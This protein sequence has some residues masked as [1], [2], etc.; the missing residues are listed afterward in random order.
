MNGLIIMLRNPDD[1]IK[2]KR[3]M[4]RKEKYVVVK[5]D[6]KSIETL[7]VQGIMGAIQ[8]YLVIY[9]YQVKEYGEDNS[10][11]KVQGY[12]YERVEG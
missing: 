4:E 11:D 7:N 3:L 8:D 12:L 9:G 5:F 6:G 2:V 1:H 10:D